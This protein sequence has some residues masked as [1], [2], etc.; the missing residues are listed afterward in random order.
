MAAAA[1]ERRYS[2]PG[3]TAL[4]FYRLAGSVSGQQVA[5]KATPWVM[6]GVRAGF[7]P[8]PLSVEGEVCDTPDGSEIVAL[9]SARPPALWPIW[10]FVLAVG[11]L[12]FFTQGPGSLVN[13]LLG[14]AILWFGVRPVVIR[15]SQR[16]SLMSADEIER[17]IGSIMSETRT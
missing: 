17:F 11:L 2:V 1:E 15:H 14:G 7:G 4:G 16:M 10:V 12:G 3:R 5:L 13:V 6:P 8:M 9:V